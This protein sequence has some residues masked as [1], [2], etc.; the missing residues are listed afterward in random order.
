MHNSFFIS[1]L[2]ICVHI[3]DVGFRIYNK[4]CTHFLHHPPWGH[5]HRFSHTGWYTQKIVAAGRYT[6]HQITCNPWSPVFFPISFCNLKI[7]VRSSVLSVSFMMFSHWFS[8]AEASVCYCFAGRARC[9]H[10]LILCMYCVVLGWPLLPSAF[11]QGAYGDSYQLF[12]QVRHRTSPGCS[13]RQV[14]S[15]LSK[16]AKL[17]LGIHQAHLILLK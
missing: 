7:K 3:A 10:F 6:S 1:K 2:P 11:W 9:N 16:P 13:E 8:V 17:W 15:E 4:M 14:L 5:M 12:G